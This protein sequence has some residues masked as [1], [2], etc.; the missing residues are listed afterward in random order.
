MVQSIS[1]ATTALGV[2][3]VKAARVTD[4]YVNKGEHCIKSHPDTILELFNALYSI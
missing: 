3:Q 2:S 1:K 4:K